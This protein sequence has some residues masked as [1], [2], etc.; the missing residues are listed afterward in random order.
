MIIILYL[1]IFAISEVWVGL[2]AIAFDYYAKK[3]NK[4]LRDIKKIKRLFFKSSLFEEKNKVGKLSFYIQII[5]YIFSLIFLLG[6]V[7]F[8]F[9]FIDILLQRIWLIVV[10]VYGTLSFLLVCTVG[11][12]AEFKKDKKK[13]LY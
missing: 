10:L 11:S 1:F 5:N 2:L 13:R 12:G 7:L 9:I 4:N 8:S 6:A 3:K